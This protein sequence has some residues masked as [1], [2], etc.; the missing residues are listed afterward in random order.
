RPHIGQNVAQLLPGNS[1][2][3]N[4]LL[5]VAWQPFTGQANEGFLVVI[6][7][8]AILSTVDAKLVQSRPHLRREGEIRCD[9]FLFTKDNS[10]LINNFG[11]AESLLRG[12]CEPI[13]KYLKRLAC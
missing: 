12:T 4:E 11:F 1:N 8:Q 10:Q 5:G 2:R 3:R 13:C 7:Q 6:E 9:T